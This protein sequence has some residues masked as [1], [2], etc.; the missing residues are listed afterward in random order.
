MYSGVVLWSILHG[1]SSGKS[2]LE[3]GGVQ[4]GELIPLVVTAGGVAPAPHIS[5]T[6]KIMFQFSLLISHLG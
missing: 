3:G 4:V 5:N 1:D 6:A 2:G